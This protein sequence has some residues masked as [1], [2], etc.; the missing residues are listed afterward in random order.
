MVDLGRPPRNGYGP[1]A[2]VARSAWSS[3]SVVTTKD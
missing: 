3:A 2:L 1:P